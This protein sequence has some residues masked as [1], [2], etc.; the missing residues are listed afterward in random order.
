MV[1]FYGSGSIAIHLIVGNFHASYIRAGK[2]SPL[3]FTDPQL[4]IKEMAVS[5]EAL[6][7]PSLPPFCAMRYSLL[8]ILTVVLW[9]RL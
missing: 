3:H 5:L 8:N 4:C 6:Y 7:A 9:L 1:S 2:N